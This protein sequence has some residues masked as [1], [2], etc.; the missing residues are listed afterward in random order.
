M[1]ITLTRLCRIAKSKGFQIEEFTPALRKEA[2]QRYNNT[3]EFTKEQANEL[4]IFIQLNCP[5]EA[6]L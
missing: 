5:E 1:I 3:C 2:K 4:A 6:Q